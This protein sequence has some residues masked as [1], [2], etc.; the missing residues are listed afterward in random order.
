MF[1]LVY[2]TKP[3]QM[4]MRCYYWRNVICMGFV[5]KI[6]NQYLESVAGLLVQPQFLSIAFLFYSN[7]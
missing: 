5:N 7:S 1:R 6:E 4:T 3:I 2:G